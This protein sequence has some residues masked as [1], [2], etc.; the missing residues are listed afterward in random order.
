MVPT[1]PPTTQLAW[2]KDNR[3]DLTLGIMINAGSQPT[4]AEAVRLGMGVGLEYNITFAFGAPAHLQIFLPDM[5]ATG[6]GVVVAGD[7]CALDAPE[8]GVAFANLLQETYRPDK[9]NDNVMYLDGVIEAMIQVE[10]LRLASLVVDPA[11]LTSADVVEKGF[12]QIKDM[13]TGGITMTPL[14]FGEG[15]PQGVDAVRI[16][17]VQNEKIVELGSYPLRNILPAPPK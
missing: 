15:D 6:N 2:L 3:V 1:A 8:D 10:A 14:T 11:K 12:R 5:G 16:Q 13:S 17:Q 9:K 7:Y 4:I